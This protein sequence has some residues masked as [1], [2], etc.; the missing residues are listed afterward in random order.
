VRRWLSVAGRDKTASAA[1]LT[2][3]GYST[4]V[5]GDALVCFDEHA[6]ARPHDV[7]LALV[8]AGCPPLRLVV[9]HE[10]LEAYFLRTVGVQD[11]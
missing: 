6:V 1:A 8:S 10:D 7:A 3:M 5:D 9:E 4:S 2:A 11:A